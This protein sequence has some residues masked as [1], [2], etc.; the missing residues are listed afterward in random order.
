[1][2]DG[3]FDNLSRKLAGPQT[4]GTMLKTLV[5]AAVG[6]ALLPVAAQAE[7]EGRNS[8]AYCLPKGHRCHPRKGVRCC[9]G[10]KCAYNPACKRLPCPHICQ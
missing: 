2:S 7:P 5:A 8:D 4:R 6:A 1:M 9:S 10:L 3:R